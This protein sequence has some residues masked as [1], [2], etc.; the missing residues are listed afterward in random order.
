MATIVH[1]SPFANGAEAYGKGKDIHSSP[2]PKGSKERVKWVNGW[3]DAQR[4]AQ[5]LAEAAEREA[6]EA[7]PLDSWCVE[8]VTR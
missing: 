5:A 4:K 6:I 8:E 2:Y 1:G 7:R 3:Q